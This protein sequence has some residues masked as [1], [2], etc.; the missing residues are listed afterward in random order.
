[1]GVK[2][3]IKKSVA[4]VSALAMA[5]SM[6][7]MPA[8]VSYAEGTDTESKGSLELNKTITLG[9]DGN[10]KLRLEAYATGEDTTST[11]PSSKPLDIVLV[12]DQSGS[13]A[14]NMGYKYEKVYSLNQYSSY[15]ISVNGEY[16][17][18]YYNSR[19]NSWGYYSGWDF[20]KVNPKTSENDTDTS[21]YQFYTREKAK[22]LDALVDAVNTFVGQVESDA[23][24]YGIDH[25][26]AIAG[27]SSSG[28]NNTEILSG[29]TISEANKIND[30][31]TSYYPKDKAYNGVQ[32]NSSGYDNAKRTAFQDV[33]TASGKANIKNAIEALTAHGG[34]QTDHGMKMAQ[35]ILDNDA[36]KDEEGRKKLVIMFTDGEPT[37]SSDSFSTTVANKAISYA[38]GIKN[39]TDYSAKIYTIGIFDN[40]NPNGTSDENNFMNYVSTNYPDATSMN[41][42]TYTKV[43]DGYYKVASDPDGLREVFEQISNVETSSST[44]VKLDSSSVL[45]DI[46]SDSFV[47]ADGADESDIKVYTA[48]SIYS[49]AGELTWGEDTLNTSATVNISEDG[50][51]IDVT[52]FDYANNYVTKNHSGQKLIVEIPINGLKS[53]NDLKSNTDLSGV[54]AKT[55]DQEA[56]EYF[57]SPIVDIPEYSYVLDYGKKVVLPNVDANT[58]NVYDANQ[59]KNYSATTMMNLGLAAPTDSKTLKGSYGTF[60]LEN[61]QLTYQPGKINWDGFDS[62]FTFGTRVSDSEYEWYKTNVIPATS[63]YYEDDFASTETVA[64]GE[65]AS[66]IKIVYGGTWNT[67][68]DKTNSKDNSQSSENTT[69]G[70]EESYSGDTNYSNGSA[71]YT[72]DIN[73]TATFTFTGT[74][75][76]VYSKTD[77]DVGLIRA[78]LYREG[79]TKAMKT[80]YIDN[81]SV[82]GTYY[83][84]PT[85][86]FDGLDYGT[87][88]VVINAG[89]KGTGGGTTYYLDGIRVYNPLGVTDE[90]IGTT[91]KDAY[92][93]AGEYNATSKEVR[94]L[95][96]DAESFDVENKAEGIVFIDKF[97]KAIGATTD[98][99]KTFEDYGPKNEVYLK[100][101]QSIAFEIQ[102][103]YENLFIGAKSPTGN[104]ITMTVSDKNEKGAKNITF[105]HASD[106]Y[107]KID[108]PASTTTNGKNVVV[109]TN[110]GSSLLSL[111]KIRATGEGYNMNIEYTPALMSYVSEFALLDAA[112]TDEKGMVVETPDT[113]VD[114]DNPS[115]EEDEDNN[116]DSFNSFWEK[117]LNELKN[118]FKK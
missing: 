110:N 107:Y 5:C 98:D 19:Q 88:K 35:D 50:K 61:N 38:K 104:E 63:V 59:S 91:A 30:R 17:Q 105:S 60:N 111:T 108:P 2:S 94:D 79:S 71:Q 51:T 117:I 83:Q 18:V 93:N 87:Y 95:L 80:L 89:G 10:Y 21:H 29:V 54:Y 55:D 102:E 56:F 8:G 22:R 14:Y 96:L 74:G 28:F 43:N 53:G 52:G 58:K 47:L 118:W 57:T 62:I 77:G 64:E 31:N 115:E 69:Y 78:Q 45:R 13:M 85:L 114:I 68:T 103:G 49:D 6:V 73:A 72:N 4:F 25:R 44:T 109:I 76:D 82:S 48:D 90:E 100:S 81:I 42:K 39:S 36:K 1:M 46:I 75:V 3:F 67:I 16:T 116:K 113:D 112:E 24:E 11:K 34:T 9:E 41:D 20:N 106:M 26:I 23:D 65:D 101:G 32:Y 92:V 12:L 7:V 33:S 97:D 70:W 37:G 86:S 66:N 40:A 27:F 15:Y 84:I 99:I